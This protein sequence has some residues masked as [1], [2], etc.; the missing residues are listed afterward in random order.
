M[1]KRVG[2]LI[3]P[4]A[5]PLRQFSG[6]FHT[7]RV[8]QTEPNPKPDQQRSSV[9]NQFLSS[10]VSIH[11]RVPIIIHEVKVVQ[12]CSRLICRGKGGR[13]HANAW[14]DI[15]PAKSLHNHTGPC[16][17]RGIIHNQ[18]QSL[19]WMYNSL[20]LTLGFLS[21]CEFLAAKTALNNLPIVSES[22]LLNQYSATCTMYMT[23]TTTI[24]AMENF[25]Y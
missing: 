20:Q 12:P 25:V 14:V 1:D 16:L 4:L 2:P 22:F 9:W 3:R 19:I 10:I 21:F 13:L 11:H 5:P 8:W 15:P 23:K 7:N 17:Q 6:E 24:R 18:T